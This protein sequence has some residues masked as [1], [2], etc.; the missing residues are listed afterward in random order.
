MAEKYIPKFFF[1]NLNVES[2]RR[3]PRFEGHYGVDSAYIIQTTNK[4]KT[5]G[6]DKYILVWYKDMT[7][8]K[9]HY[10]I[11]KVINNMKAFYPSTSDS[12]KFS[13]VKWVGSRNNQD[14]KLRE[15]KKVGKQFIENV[16]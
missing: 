6:V 5:F 13:N 9:N 3:E 1:E 15:V 14:G 4:K 8:G 7:D 10:N 16:E 11:F 2:I 12:E